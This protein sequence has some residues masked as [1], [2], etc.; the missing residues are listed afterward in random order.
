MIHSKLY[1][2]ERPG[3]RRVLVGSANLSERALSGRQGEVLVAYDN[4]PWMWDRMLQKYEAV[5]SLSPPLELRTQIKEA[6]LVLAQDLPAGRQAELDEKEAA[7]IY[8]FSPT[9]IPGDPEYL[10]VRAEEIYSHLGE[11]LREQIKPL[12]NGT[13]VL[14]KAALRQINYAAAPKRADDPAK[15]HR[16]ERAESRFIY[17]GRAVERPLDYAGIER[18]ALLISQFIDKFRE[19]GAGSD[20]LQRN[21]YGLWGWLYFSPFM[22]EL[23]RKIHTM[24]GNA[25]KE[26]KHLAVVYG[27]S[28][29]G[30]SALTKFLLT[31]MFGPP[32]TFDD[33][34]FTQSDFKARTARVGILP[35]YYED[36]SGSR[37]AGR[38]QNQGEV[39]VK[40][41]DQLVSRT[42]QYPCAIVTANADA[43]QFGN[44]VRN[45]AFLVYTPKGIASDDDNTRRRLDR[46]VLPLLNRVGQDF[47]GEYL[48]RMSGILSDVQDPTEF[49]YLWEYTALIRE[50]LIENLKGGEVLP[51]WAKAVTA[52]GFNGLAWELKHREMAKK[53]TRKLYT[54]NFPP[55]PPYWTAND[56][57]IIIG[58]ESVRDTMRSKEFQDHWV[59]RE[60]TYGKLLALHRQA[61]EESIQRTDPDWKLPVP[62]LKRLASSLRRKIA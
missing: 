27:Q 22:P 18:D 28:N 11:G 10:A 23:A 1:F 62:A 54:P 5:R 60:G 39:I 36:V 59:K 45:R 47:Y 2:L 33:S 58:V 4:D 38:N 40:Y 3:L 15:L 14:H 8:T 56:T 17:D 32:S 9:D 25:S 46:E 55:P 37:F 43:G 21:Y 44:E 61:V 42:G 16:L 24:G 29:C 41:Y 20:I 49:D 52:S 53:L 6:H 31:S 13:A 7:T 34:C 26:L 12:P 35:I 48:H 57:E 30:K 50:I 19:F 51:E